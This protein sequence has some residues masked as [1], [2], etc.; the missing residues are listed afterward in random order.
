MGL[1][2]ERMLDDKGL[3]SEYFEKNFKAE[4][5]SAARS[6]TNNPQDAELLVRKVI[7]DA[8]EQAVH[9]DMPR[10]VR[11]D[12]GFRLSQ[13]YRDYGQNMSALR[14]LMSD[15]AAAQENKM[16]QTIAR[17]AEKKENPTEKPF[18][19]EIRKPSAKAFQEAFSQEKPSA[20]R[21]DRQTN[22]WLRSAVEDTREAEGFVAMDFG[23]DKRAH[24]E[25]DEE[26]YSVSS[27]AKTE[28]EPDV[29]TIEEKRGESI[30]EQPI[31]I[32]VTGEEKPAKGE[33]ADYTIQSDGKERIEEAALTEA[34]RERL[35]DNF[36]L[37][38]MQE[39]SD[40]V[41]TPILPAVSV[42][43]VRAYLMNSDVSETTKANQP[44]GLAAYP[45]KMHPNI[46]MQHTDVYLETYYHQPYSSSAAEEN[47]FS[48]VRCGA[49]AVEDEVYDDKNG[50]AAAYGNGDRAEA[51]IVLK[52]PA[53][54]ESGRNCE[55]I[56][57]VQ[58]ESTA[59]ANETAYNPYKSTLW[60]VNYEQNQCVMAKDEREL[61]PEDQ[62][63]DD[64]DEERSVFLS[65]L[66]TILVLTSMASVGLLLWESG[67][68]GIF[69]K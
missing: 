66:N 61:Y 2:E 30:L 10:N 27:E 54:P 22:I 32:H 50:Y 46:C 60:T 41:M 14:S 1:S 3:A 17:N 23:E 64:E 33:E 45:E 35:D 63:D 51:H 59:L 49:A 19:G 56:S 39:H 44:K 62:P 28:D 36:A 24:S 58:N 69:F 18:A 25:A 12:L 11:M 6:Y 65:I 52:E 29:Q 26:I 47:D 57:Y 16:P 20:V 48:S 55:S 68:L 9:G 38:Q 21:K 7:A 42:G 40:A 13:A 43:Q 31:V 34:Y 8:S 67:V 53:A 15:K 5:L 4:L 37:E